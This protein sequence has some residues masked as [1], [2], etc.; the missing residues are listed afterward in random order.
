MYFPSSNHLFASETEQVAKRIMVQEDLQSGSAACGLSSMGSSVADQRQNRSKARSFLNSSFGNGVLYKLR[1][2]Y[3][4][5]YD[6]ALSSRPGHVGL[7]DT[8]VD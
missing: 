8:N 4:S 1:H 6:Q 5:D 7:R 2:S 3:G